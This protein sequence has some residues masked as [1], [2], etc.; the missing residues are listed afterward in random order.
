MGRGSDRGTVPR[1]RT[2]PGQCD[3]YGRNR[4]I[5]R[6]V[7]THAQWRRDRDGK[8]SSRASPQANRRAGGPIEIARGLF[9]TLLCRGR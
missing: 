8:F 4:A 5:G 3:R 6:G 1:Y 7:R 9:R 2:D